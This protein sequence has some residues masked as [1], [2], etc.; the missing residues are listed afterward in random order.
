MITK[1]VTKWLTARR[2][3]ADWSADL[4]PL[5][6]VAVAVAE[7]LD[8]GDVSGPLVKELRATLVDLARPTEEE[9]DAFEL[10]A[11][12]LSAAVQHTED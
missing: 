8:L 3:D 6:A 7:R 1:A 9:A 4:E 11:A 12:E 10:L 5:A 2:K